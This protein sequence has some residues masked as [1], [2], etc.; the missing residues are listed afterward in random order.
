[1]NVISAQ[2]V[3]RRGLAAID[4]LIPQGPVH[5]IKNNT[6]QYVVLTEERYQELINLENETYIERLKLSLKEVKQGKVSR[7]KHVDDLL[8]AIDDV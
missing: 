7:F 2:E 4:D 1:M 8:K 3:K 5:L 6:P